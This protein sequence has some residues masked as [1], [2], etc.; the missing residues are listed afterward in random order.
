MKY[1][2]LVSL[3]SNRADNYISDDMRIDREETSQDIK[4]FWDKILII[5]KDIIHS[6][7]KN[8]RKKIFYYIN[9]FSIVE[10]ACILS[11]SNNFDKKSLLHSYR[12]FDYRY[13]KIIDIIRKN[14]CWS[15]DFKKLIKQECPEILQSRMLDW[16]K[17][18]RKA[19]PKTTIICPVCNKKFKSKISF[20]NH[21]MY[22]KYKSEDIIKKIKNNDL[23]SRNKKINCYKHIKF[24]ESQEKKIMKLYK[25]RDV[26]LYKIYEE[27]KKDPNF[28]LGHKWVYKK[29]KKIR[30]AICSN[31]IGKVH[32][33]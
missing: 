16:I 33:L 11:N 7:D 9:N 20:G 25:N 18:S 17:T 14:L 19:Y 3:D 27:L 31:R 22:M 23:L 12:N 1:I 24:I 15:R 32:Y 8:K 6:L 2:R 5:I 26:S 30:E 13:K 29:D 21:L 28:Y 4:L 10:M